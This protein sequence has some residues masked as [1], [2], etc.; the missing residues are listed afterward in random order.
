MLLF[1]WERSLKNASQHKNIK[2]LFKKLFNPAVVPWKKLRSQY[3][4]V[5]MTPSLKMVLNTNKKINLLSNTFYCFSNVME[6]TIHDC[7][8][9]G[10][11]YRSSC[12]VLR[13]WC[14]DIYC[15]QICTFCPSISDKGS[16][17]Y[18]LMYDTGWCFEQMDLF[19][20]KPRSCK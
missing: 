1:I 6:Y 13:R 9:P 14:C 16:I 17:F 7:F 15:R 2:H 12:C 5:S 11:D 20:L 4:G 10:I 8:T 19:L 18:V 3:L